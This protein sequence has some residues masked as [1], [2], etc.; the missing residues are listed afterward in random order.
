MDF[1]NKHPN[2]GQIGTYR[3]ESDGRP[4]DFMWPRET[5]A[6]LRG[7]KSLLRH[8][9]HWRTWRTLRSLYGLATA[10]GYQAGEHVLG[11][12]L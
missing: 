7:I 1:F 9:R 12:A 2:A 10:R 5:L 8:P 6:R 3:I 11:G 4:S